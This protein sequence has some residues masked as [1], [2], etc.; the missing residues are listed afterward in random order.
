MERQRNEERSESNE[1][2]VKEPTRMV[3][4]PGLEPT[5]MVKRWA[6]WIPFP[7]LPGTGQMV[8]LTNAPLTVPQQFYRVRQF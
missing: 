8:T 7:L 6:G 4:V 5:L 1:G 2:T 3:L